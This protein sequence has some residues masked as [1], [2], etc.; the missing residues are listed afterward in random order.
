MLPVAPESIDVS[1]LPPMRLD[2]RL[3]FPDIPVV[4]FALLNDEILYIGKAKNLIQRW[5]QHHRQAELEVFSEVKIAWI[6]FSDPGLLRVVEKALIQYFKPKFN[7]QLIKVR[8]PK[9]VL[10]KARNRTGKGYFTVKGKEPLSKRT[11]TLRLPESVDAELRQEIGDGLSDW[12]RQVIIE[13][14]QCEKRS[15]TI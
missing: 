7:Q 9:A 4:Y 6:E 1:S 13:K 14:W 5:R 10:G 2:Q 11:I 8:P 3:E 12:M 15:K